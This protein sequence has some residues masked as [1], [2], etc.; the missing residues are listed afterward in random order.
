MGVKIY[1]DEIKEVLD[2]NSTFREILFKRGYC[3]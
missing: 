3:T 2:Q 1:R